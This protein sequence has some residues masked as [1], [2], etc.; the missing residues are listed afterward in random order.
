MMK[1]QKNTKE[2]PNQY[3]SHLFNYNQS[4]N[5]DDRGDSKSQIIFKTTFEC[6]EQ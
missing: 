6:D 3:E 1:S 2:K 4:E 5:N